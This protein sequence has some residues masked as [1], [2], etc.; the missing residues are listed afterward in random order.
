[1]KTIEQANIAHLLYKAEEVLK[2]ICDVNAYAICTCD[3]CRGSYKLTATS[4]FSS[5]WKKVVYKI[6]E[7]H[8]DIFSIFKNY[9]DIK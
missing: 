5:F 7:I 2:N 6:E 8:C 1:M 4:S 3:I 9:R